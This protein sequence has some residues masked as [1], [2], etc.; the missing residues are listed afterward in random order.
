MNDIS[1]KTPGGRRQST[2]YVIGIGF[3]PDFITLR[4]LHI[5]R[6]VNRVF[7]DGYTNVLLDNGLRLKEVLSRDYEVLGRRDIEDLNAKE[8]FDALDS[9]DVAFLVPGD[10]LIATTHINLVIEA[11]RRG[12]RVEIIPGVSIVSAAISISGLTSYKFGKT[13]T[14][15]YPKNGVVYEYV[16]EVIKENSMRNLHTL[17]LL[18]IDVERGI[19]MSIGDAVKILFQLENLRGEGVIREDRLAVGISRLGGHD[20]KACSDTIN[21]LIKHDFGSPPHTLILTSPKLHFIEEKALEVIN[22]I[23]CR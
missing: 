22:D 8:V 13:A 15:V 11:W 2:L 16:Y 10:A 19:F 3:S 5:V 6:N 7:L 4:T 21:N 14:I 1:N 17:L 18:E 9:G 12:Y 23:Y 20:M